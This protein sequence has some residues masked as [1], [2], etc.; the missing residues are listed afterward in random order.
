MK[1]EEMKDAVPTVSESSAFL[2]R[3]VIRWGQLWGWGAEVN[4]K[5]GSVLHRNGAMVIHLGLTLPAGSSDQ[6]ES[7]GR[8][9][10]KHFPIRSCSR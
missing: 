5:P 4:H 3:L 2:S 9:A 10:L 1:P 6:P 7:I 8:A